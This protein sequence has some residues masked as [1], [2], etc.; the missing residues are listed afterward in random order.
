MRA[1]A[2]TPGLIA[3]ANFRPSAAT[4]LRHAAA[5]MPHADNALAA[6]IADGTRPPDDPALAALPD[7]A[8]RAAV[9]NT[10]FDLFRYRYLTDREATPEEQHR[11]RAILLAR[12]QVPYAG[13]GLDP[14]PTPAVRPDEGHRSMR[15]SL[16]SGAR[17]GKYYVEAGARLAY[18]DLLDPGGGYTPGAAISAGDLLFRY[19]TK[20][21]DPRV[22]RFTL[23]DITSLSPLDA[24]FHPISWT[25]GTGLDN[26]LLPDAHDALREHYVWHTHGG[27]GV[28]IAPWPRALLY[29]FAQA[30]VDWS[31]SLAEDH[32][33]GPQ[34]AIGVYAGPASD[35]WRAHL[36]GSVT[37]FVLGDTS[38]WYRGGLD[39][40]LTL[41]PQMALRGGV[42][43]NR[44]FDQSWVEGGVSWD[45][46]F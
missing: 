30:I 6:A 16:G 29:G 28:A 31:P 41:T 4:R 19:Y 3:G 32:A 26:R 17:D 12:S 34:G 24:F 40:R 43:G 2:D 14:V 22:E 42:S 7:D 27:P 46:F 44:D 18:H 10:A 5:T 13:S 45:L 20:D 9:L 25:V 33:I 38:Q 21:R 23:V 37:G 39:L 35:R 8:A 11:A 36:Y 1:V 15:A